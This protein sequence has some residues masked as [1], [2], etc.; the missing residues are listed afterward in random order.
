MS[1]T[2][3]GTNDLSQATP[4]SDT[5]DNREIEQK[6]KQLA[7]WIKTD[8][9]PEEIESELER[10]VD[11]ARQ[12]QTSNLLDTLLEAMPEKRELFEPVTKRPVHDIGEKVGI[13]LD[14]DTKGS[15]K[16]IQDNG[17]NQALTEVETII[18]EMQK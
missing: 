8:L 16:F 13:D 1:K 4:H 11:Q 18:K 3:D 14:A 10:L 12:S 17:Y 15:L 7:Y 5:K 2:N 6:I 9:V